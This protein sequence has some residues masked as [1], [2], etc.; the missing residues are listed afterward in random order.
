MQT[1]AVDPFSLKF[2]SLLDVFHGIIEGDP[3]PESVSDKLI[4]LKEQ[5]KNTGELNTRQLEAILAR[6]DNYLKGDYGKTK[7]ADNYGHTKSN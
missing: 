6:C 2:S 7:N 1:A 3:K 5:A 4:A